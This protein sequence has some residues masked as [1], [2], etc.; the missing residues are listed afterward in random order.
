MRGSASRTERGGQKNRLCN[1]FLAGSGFL[2]ILRVNLDA[3]DTLSGVRHCDRDQF[4]VLPRNL[5]ILSSNDSV[6]ICPR[7]EF[8]RSKLRH[9][10][11]QLQIVFIVVVVGHD[12]SPFECLLISQAQHAF[13]TSIDRTSREPFE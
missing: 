7:L 8:L 12:C 6:Q 11:Q 3:V 9:F 10:S 2:R 5:S 13:L 4:P 1:F